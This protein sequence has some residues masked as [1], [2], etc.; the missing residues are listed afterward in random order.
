MCIRDRYLTHAEQ[1]FQTMDSDS[2]GFVVPEEMR[3]HAKEMRK[4][5]RKAKRAAR[6][7]SDE[8]TRSAAEDI[9]GP[10]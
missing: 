10:Q 5:H 9:T 1:R 4:K 8:L 7:A 6:S 2:N 3:A